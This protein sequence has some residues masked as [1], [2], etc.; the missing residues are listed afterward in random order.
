MAGRGSRFATA[1]YSIPKPLI[2]VH[3]VPMIRAVVRNLTPSDID[4][5]YTFIVLQDHIREY[6]V[7]QALQTLV[8]GCSVVSVDRVTEGAAS[9]CCW[10]AI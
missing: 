6:A 7:D 8:P 4:C 3:G 9:Q 1:G 5:H 2:P 10:P